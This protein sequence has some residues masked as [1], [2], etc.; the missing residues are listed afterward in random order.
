MWSS[1]LLTGDGDPL[2][3]V[4]AHQILESQLQFDF[5][6][7]RAAGVGGAVRQGDLLTRSKSEAQH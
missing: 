6:F 7:G 2:E 1:H 5:A 3:T 4:L